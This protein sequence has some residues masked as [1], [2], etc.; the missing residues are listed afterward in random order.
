MVPFGYAP[1]ARLPGPVRVAGREGLLDQAR[2]VRG[3]SRRSRA[4]LGAGALALIVAL[5]AAAAFTTNASWDEFA[6]LHL[7]DET[8][9][10]GVLH[11]GGRPGLAVLALLPF[12]AHCDDELEVIRRARLLWLALTI[13]FV[14][15]LAAWL[16]ELDP[17]PDR[18]AG[19]ALVGVALLT[20]VPAFLE[21]S[22]QVRSDHIA[23]AGGTWGGAALLA[24]RRRPGLAAAAGALFAVG[25]LGSQKLVYVAALAALLA[26]G[27]CLRRRELRLRREAARAA[28]AGAAFGVVLLVFRAATSRLFA[29]PGAHPSQQGLTP[30]YVDHG[31]SIFEYYRRSIG[32]SQYLEMLPTLLPHGLAIA[33]LVAAGAAALRRPRPGDGALAL[34]GAALVL[35]IAVGAFHAAA[36]RY[37]WLTLGLFPAVAVAVSRHALRERLLPGTRRAARLAVAGWWVLLVVPGVLETGF[38]LRD[39][40][41]VQRESLA[42]VHRNFA[43]SDAG[44]HPESG[45]FCQDA[46]QPIG[47]HFSQHIQRRFAGPGRERNAAAMERTFRETPIKFIVQSFRLNQFPLELR[48][49]WAENYQPYRAAVFVAGRRLGGARGERHDFEL[50]VAGRYR[51]LPFAGPRSVEVDGRRIPAGGVLALGSGA[52]VARFVEEVPGGMLVLAVDEPPGDAP[53]SFYEPVWEPGL[54]LRLAAFAA[55]EREG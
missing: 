10:T 54:S 44:F 53:R 40:Q 26:A 32:M 39:S 46:P 8:A 13:A 22:V 5:R 4:L 14:A 38:M 21:T 35:G 47:T 55:G 36:F 9:A 50:L 45:L 25:F 52:H 2:T 17:G 24:S 20:L 28:L 48:R 42:F 37:F 29:V 11:T 51:W 33:A 12:V 43:R 30:A 41:A 23:L 34:G 3:L 49:F 27:D 1:T 16:A 31:F 19:T 6:L 18:R 7:A 15:G